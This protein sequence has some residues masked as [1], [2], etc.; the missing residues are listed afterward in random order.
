MIQKPHK[1]M[2]VA[3]CVGGNEGTGKSMPFVEYFS[4]ILGKNLFAYYQN[5]SD[6]TGEFNGALTNKLLILVDECLFGKLIS[7]IILIYF[8]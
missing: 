4:K 3:I 2:E 8:S 7:V 5:M 1:K 6:L